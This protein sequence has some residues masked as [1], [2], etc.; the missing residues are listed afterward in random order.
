MPVCNDCVFFV[1]HQ[2]FFPPCPSPSLQV[3]GQ[4]VR[5]LSHEALVSVLRAAPTRVALGVVRG[6]ARTK[7]L[8]RKKSRDKLREQ[9]LQ[10]SS[11]DE[12]EEGSAADAQQR[13]QSRTQPAVTS[14]A[15]ATTATTAAAAGTTAQQQ[16][17]GD[18]DEE[19]EEEGEGEEM[20]VDGEP[21]DGES[22]PVAASAVQLKHDDDGNAVAEHGEVGL[23]ASEA[24]SSPQASS[25]AVGAPIKSIPLHPPRTLKATRGPI[26]EVRVSKRNGPVGL[27]LCGGNNTG[28]GG[29]FIEQIVKGSPAAG[30]GLRASNRLLSA[31]RTALVVRVCSEGIALCMCG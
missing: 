17:S 11:D 23:A 8:Q 1:C 13:R 15:A 30:A 5:A 7:K 18:H 24:G 2:T 27:R 12:S 22:A 28:M 14:A 4:D 10:R 26:E 9:R 25:R 31:N 29:I 6:D 16:Q 19:E 3:N 21:L 20:D